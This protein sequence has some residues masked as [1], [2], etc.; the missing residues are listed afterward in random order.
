[1]SLCLTYDGVKEINCNGALSGIKLNGAGIES[2]TLDLKTIY[3]L[4]LPVFN[5]REFSTFASGLFT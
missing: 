5:A 1:M 4:Q 3:E 2:K